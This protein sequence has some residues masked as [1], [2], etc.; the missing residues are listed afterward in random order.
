M[1]TEKKQKLRRN[2][3]RLSES[4]G[5]AVNELFDI[6]NSSLFGGELP[7]P[8]FLLYLA[9][10]RTSA[11]FLKEE[12]TIRLMVYVKE[13]SVYAE[14][15]IGQFGFEKD[16]KAELLE[17]I[18][19]EMCHLWQAPLKEHLRFLFDE[20]WKLSQA[21]N[22]D[23]IR[24]REA[25]NKAYWIMHD[26]QFAD[27][28][29]SLGIVETHS[30]KKMQYTSLE[31]IVPGGLFQK[32]LDNSKEQIEACLDSLIPEMLSYI[33]PRAVRERIG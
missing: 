21:K 32:T 4:G 2:E 12:N 15:Y 9:R 3:R 24:R 28:M 29:R 33:K 5:K 23:E 17:S 22:F 8:R 13:N 7:R 31:Q 16:C 11:D 26:S 20:Y 10:S 19:H 18:V 27:K 30:G 6:F 25:E 1:D 14:P